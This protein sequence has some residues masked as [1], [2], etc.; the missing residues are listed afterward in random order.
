MTANHVHALITL[1]LI[2]LIIIRTHQI[3]SKTK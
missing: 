3:E 2:T 1:T